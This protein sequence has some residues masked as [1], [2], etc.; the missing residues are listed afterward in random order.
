MLV[1]HIYLGPSVTDWTLARRLARPSVQS[2]DYRPFPILDVTKEKLHSN[3]IF[4]CW[5]GF[6]NLIN[7]KVV[8][9]IEKVCNCGIDWKN[10]RKNTYG[11]I[12]N[13]PYFDSTL[14]YCFSFYFNSKNIANLKQQTEK[15]LA[16]TFKL[17]KQE[18]K[19]TK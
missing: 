4:P 5:L 12:L 7:L 2:S 3:R 9:I 18:I 17:Q 10:T 16:L 11:L 14:F 13:S 1:R 6:Q 8:R 15:F 19:L